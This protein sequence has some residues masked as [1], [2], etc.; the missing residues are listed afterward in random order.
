MSPRGGLAG[1]ASPDVIVV[2]RA[3]YAILWLGAVGRRAQLP[4]AEAFPHEQCSF[5]W[6][7]EKRQPTAKHKN[8]EVV[9]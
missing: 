8:K 7:A 2:L 1:G 9:Q 4:R 6:P 5:F 3:L